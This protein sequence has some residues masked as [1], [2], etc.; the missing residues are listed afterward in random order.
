MNFDLKLFYRVVFLISLIGLFVTISDFGFTHSAYSHHVLDA[1]YFVVLGL[2]IVTTALRYLYKE[3]TINRKVII[4][5]LI[6]GTFTLWVIYLYLF[7]GIPFQTDMVL[8]N[9]IWLKIAVVFT[10]IRESSE[11]K[12]NFKRKVLNPAQLFIL[13]FLFYYFDWFL[14]LEFT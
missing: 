9:E 5:D 4:F 6:S 11:L 2:G 12:I 3:K 14:A 8:D 1:F 7:T 13:S 10:F